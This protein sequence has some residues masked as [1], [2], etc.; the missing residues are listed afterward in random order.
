MSESRSASQ[1]L[2]N[3][4]VNGDLTV[5]GNV[6]NTGTLT[7]TGLVTATAGVDSNGNT[8]VDGLNLTS[9]TLTGNDA[10]SISIPLSVCTSA[11]TQAVSLED[12][13]TVGQIKIFQAT[14]ADDTTITPTTTA[15]AYATV[16]L[17]NIGDTLILIWTGVGWAILS[18]AS[19]AAAAVD[20]V[21]AMPLIAA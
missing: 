15:G 18:R 5:T 16:K 1:K 20:A 2:Y 19:G 9:E 14:N 6:A 21:V 10:A 13:N 4:N 8:L 7:S 17:T 3:L 12:G 11:G